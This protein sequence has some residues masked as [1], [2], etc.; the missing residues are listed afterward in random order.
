MADRLRVEAEESAREL[1][2]SQQEATE[3]LEATRTLLRRAE[4]ELEALRGQHTEVCKRLEQEQLKALNRSLQLDQST[5]TSRAEMETTAESRIPTRIPV[6]DSGSG[7][8]SVREKA[9]EEGDGDGD[10]ERGGRK[11]SKELGLRGERKQGEGSSG[12]GE[13][14]AVGRG[15]VDYERMTLPGVGLK[16]PRKIVM[17]SE[18]S[19]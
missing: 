2:H 11:T 15:V 8:T 18:R 3:H 6:Q 12:E 13:A 14:K 19:R 17:L 1:R 7:R 10:G 4:S 9:K 5:Q 16:D